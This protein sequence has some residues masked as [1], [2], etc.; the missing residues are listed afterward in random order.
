[1]EH[2]ISVEAFHPETVSDAS[3]LDHHFRRSPY[4]TL[5]ICY[6]GVR[7]KDTALHPAVM[8]K[9]SITD[10]RKGHGGS[11]ATSSSG[12]R[13]KS[14]KKNGKKNRKKTSSASSLG[15]TGVVETASRG[16]ATRDGGLQGT[17]T[18]GRSKTIMKGDG[19]IGAGG[20]GGGGEEA[21]ETAPSKK[22]SSSGAKKVEDE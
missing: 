11:T 12:G 2:D 8:A 9:K 19:D 5:H 21:T 14:G 7:E 17:G 22:R 16:G 20:G 13:R 4:P 3:P 10:A 6:H 18:R 15:A 1:M